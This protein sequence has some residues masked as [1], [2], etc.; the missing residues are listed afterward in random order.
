MNV[1]PAIP[2]T[3]STS[4]DLQPSTRTTAFQSTDSGQGLQHTGSFG[5]QP[6]PVS[7]NNHDGLRQMRE[8][9]HRQDTAELTIICD[10][11]TTSIDSNCHIDS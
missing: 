4:Q 7:K 1:S 3:N 6:F 10:S 2:E 11:P 9:S 5:F 8:A